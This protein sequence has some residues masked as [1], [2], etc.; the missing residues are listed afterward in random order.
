MS[1]TD[2]EYIVLIVSLLALFVVG[3][4][5]KAKSAVN[6]VGKCKFSLSV[7]LNMSMA[8]KGLAC[9]FVLMGHYAT[10]ELP[11]ELPWGVSKIVKLFSANI[12]LFWFMFF[13][14]YGLSLKSNKYRSSSEIVRTWGKRIKKI[15]FPL[16]ITCCAT[17]LI[18]FLFPFKEGI[19][20]GFALVH[21]LNKDTIFPVLKSTLGIW[22]WY[23]LCIFYFYTFF[24]ISA[25]VEKQFKIKQT[26]I[27]WGLLVIYL[28]IAI[29]AYGLSM[30]HYYRYCWAFFCGHIVARWG[31]IQNRMLAVAGCCILA[32]S[33]FFEDSL[34]SSVRFFVAYSAAMV[35]I[36]NVA[37]INNKYE[38]KGKV[39]L[40]LGAVSYFFYLA[41]V[42]IGYFITA[43]FNF[44]DLVVWTIISFVVAT[45][46]TLLYNRTVRPAK[47]A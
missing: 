40:F 33:L 31:S 39:I 1:I 2:A 45:V 30:A 43:Y 18:Y 27:L 6:N 29:P 23:V 35:I 34:F 17:T 28:I 4:K 37:L 25:F 20:D 46:L 26:Y 14:G 3:L 13:S 36:Y 24:Y 42:R 38:M 21:H 47:K 19:S 7:D 11:T 22:D 12:A 15:Y 8:M 10:L 9:V 32:V 41:H 16:L 44:S 5:P